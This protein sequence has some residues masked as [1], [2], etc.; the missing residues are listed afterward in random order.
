MKTDTKSITTENSWN[1][2]RIRAIDE[3]KYYITE[4]EDA[5]KIIN[6]GLV[7]YGFK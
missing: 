7:G 5:L 3:S 1:D 4:D 2:R 6:E